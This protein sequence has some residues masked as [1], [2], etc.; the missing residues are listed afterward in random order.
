MM[1]DL[2]PGRSATLIPSAKERARAL[3]AK[4][5]ARTA[6][7]DVSPRGSR[8][9]RSLPTEVPPPEPLPTPA[10]EHVATPERFKSADEQT[11]SETGFNDGNEVMPLPDVIDDLP[12]DAGINVPSE[13]IP[14]TPVIEPPVDPKPAP[15]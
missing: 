4:S 2:S 9:K 11:V 14:Q 12:V 6:P 8:S 1:V 13:V 10:V 15:P 7:P 5:K 3:S